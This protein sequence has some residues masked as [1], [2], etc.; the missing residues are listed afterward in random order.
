MNM[1]YDYLFKL[2][3]VGDSGVGKSCLLLRFVDDAFTDSFISTIGVDFKIKTLRLDG[4]KIKLQL[5]DTAGQERF[6]TITSSYYRGAHGV[7]LV[8]DVTE[9]G[10]F[11]HIKNW[12]NDVM[13]SGN[14][15]ISKILVGNKCDMVD[16]RCISQNDGSAFAKSLNIPFI[17]TSAKND[18]SIKEIFNIITKE[19]KDKLPSNINQQSTS[20]M[21]DAMEKDN[22]NSCGC[23]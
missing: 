13:K 18:V 10:S 17:E 2:I 12:L 23:V 3:I 19:I 1:D 4:K 16:Q 22:K 14:E 8:Y 5:W 7:V 11:E 21:L 9:I 20:L 15:K 6:K